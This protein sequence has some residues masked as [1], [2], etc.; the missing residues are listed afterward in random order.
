M[1]SDFIDIETNQKGPQQDFA[2]QDAI[3]RGTEL[4]YF[5][6][7]ST[8]ILLWPNRD[9]KWTVKEGE[10][11]RMGES[12]AIMLEGSVTAPKESQHKI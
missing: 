11:I 5:A 8:V 2:R 12:I 10:S 1:G 6:L 9:L 7:G 4:G 3:I